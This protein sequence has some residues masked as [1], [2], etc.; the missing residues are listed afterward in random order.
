MNIKGNTVFWPTPKD[1]I[2]NN[3]FKNNEDIVKPLPDY[4]SGVQYNPDTKPGSGGSSIYESA[5][6]L[7]NTMTKHPVT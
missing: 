4:L 2:A 1:S 7:L 3:L 6:N 5:K